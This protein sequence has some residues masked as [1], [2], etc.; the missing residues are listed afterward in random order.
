MQKRRFNLIKLATVFSGIGAIEHALKRMQLEHKIVFACDNGDVDILSKDVG[1]NINDIGS[2][3]VLL[4][5]KVKEIHHNNEIQDLYKDQL[6]GMLTEA[7][8]EY[9][10][11]V[12][13][14]KTIELAPQKIENVINQIIN[15]ESIKNSRSKEYTSFKKE[16]HLGSKE[17]QTFRQLQII[18]EIVNDYK[19]DNPLESLGQSAEFQS[20]DNINWALVSAE[21]KNIYDTL[22]MNDG[23]KIIR[24]VQDLSQRVGQLHEKINYIAVQKRLEE[25]GTDWDARK[26]YVDSLYLGMEQKNKVKQSYMAN[27]ELS[28]SNYHWNVAFLDGNQYKG[29]VDLFVGGGE[30]FGLFPK[31]LIRVMDEA[32]IEHHDG[33]FQMAIGLVAHDDGLDFDEA[34]GL[35]FVITKTA[36][37]RGE[38]ILLA[39]GV[40]ELVDF[41]VAGFFGDLIS[42][43]GF[44]VIGIKKL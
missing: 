12:Q 27:Y 14:I 39:N 44:L 36:K 26:K 15:S 4:K 40:A 16:L 7:N 38:L 30:V 29:N 31:N 28:D 37:S 41:D 8:S 21:L 23:K 18:L 19:K 32:R 2:E 3:L 11:L 34:I 9:K 22:E 1:M 17:Q 10:T 33:A 43:N 5:N 35:E 6:I 20:T 42:R 25:L 13:S 24:K